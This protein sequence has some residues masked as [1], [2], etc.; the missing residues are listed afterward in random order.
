MRV[1]ASV[2][3][4]GAPFEIPANHSGTFPALLIAPRVVTSF[5]FYTLGHRL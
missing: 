5:D 2:E 3:G 4:M 1:S